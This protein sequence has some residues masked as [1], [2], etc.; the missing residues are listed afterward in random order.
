MEEGFILA[1]AQQDPKFFP[2]HPELRLKPTLLLPRLKALDDLV[3]FAKPDHQR[4]TWGEDV[5]A[6]DLVNLAEFHGTHRRPARPAGDGLAVHGLAAPRRQDDLRVA[7]D[8]V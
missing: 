6:L 3:D 2:G 1:G 4:G 5:V 8:H 7:G